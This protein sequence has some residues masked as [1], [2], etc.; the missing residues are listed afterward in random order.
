MHHMRPTLPS[1]RYASVS[2][3]G[4]TIS[5]MGVMNSPAGTYDAKF[6]E[7][8]DAMRLSVV[9]GRLTKVDLSRKWRC[10]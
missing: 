6:E 2:E 5:S 7:R 1:S 10:P 3:S 8:F 9:R 4:E